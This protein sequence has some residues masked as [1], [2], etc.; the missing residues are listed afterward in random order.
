[1]STQRLSV[2]S[3]PSLSDLISS[4][5]DSDDYSSAPLPKTSLKI[6][7]GAPPIATPAHVSTIAC[8]ADVDID[9]STNQLV[10][11]NQYV[12]IPKNSKVIYVK[13]SG[14]KIQNKY[15][16][17]YDHLSD[18]IIL[19]FYVHDK[20]NYS[21]KI[22]NIKQLFTSTKTVLGGAG[23]DILKGT[24]ELAPPD[25]KN[26]A[27]DMII[28]YKKKD[29]EWVYKAKFNAFV[30]SPKDQSTRFSMTSEKGYSF[31]TNP[32]NIDKMY[33]HLSTSDKTFTQILKMLQLMQQQMGAVEKK[34][35]Q[36]DVR[37]S[38][39]EQRI[40]RK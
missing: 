5:D 27:R 3:R 34:V 32:A 20:R 14:K 17:S 35:S 15:F 12:S 25:W 23:Q 16:K 26:L 9:T 13:T 33:R 4:S 8:D 22:S 10:D 11:P 40:R 21:E 2:A 38:N 29:G 36:L 6:P 19:G 7:G 1:M 28:S 31:V 18:S 30:K 37:L 39:I 24:L